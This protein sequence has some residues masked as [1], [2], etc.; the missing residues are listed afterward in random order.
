MSCVQCSK[1]NV[2]VLI[3]VDPACMSAFGADTMERS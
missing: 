3:E 1:N 2:N